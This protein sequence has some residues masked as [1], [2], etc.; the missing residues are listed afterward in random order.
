MLAS[1]PGVIPIDDPHLGHH[2]GVWRPISLAWG[3][4]DSPPELTTLD[5]IKLERDSY[6][7]SERYRDA[8]EPALRRLVVERFDA[9]ARHCLASAPDRFPLGV[10]PVVVVKEPGSQAAEHL[11]GLLPASRL[12]FLLRDGRDVIDSWLAAY[13]EGSWAMEEGAFAV[14]DGPGRLALVRWLGAVWAYR[15]CN[16]LRAWAAH[17]P[18]RR[19]LV[20]YED[21]VADPA[22]RL[23]DVAAVLGLAVEE[24]ALR[25]VARDASYERVPDEEKG[26]GKFVRSARPGDW[27]VNLTPDEQ[28][29]AEQAMG[30]ALEAVGYARAATP[31]EPVP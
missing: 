12:V 28:V 14:P 18:G 5:R 1:L 11:L 22:G 3:L 25:A 21:L 31:D 10:G 15:T 19:L 6:F 26:E 29:A 27:R 9:E 4:A 2:L 16:V 20:R 30:D 7:F 13:R 24:D 23:A 8:W 17:P